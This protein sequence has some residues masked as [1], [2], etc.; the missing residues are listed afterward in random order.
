[1][2]EV[3]GHSLGEDTLE[4][5]RVVKDAIVNFGSVLNIPITHTLIMSVKNS[6]QKYQADLEAKRR[7]KE[8]TERRKRAIEKEAEQLKRKFAKDDE[9]SKID[10][11]IKSKRDG[12][13]VADETIS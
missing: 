9:V 5:L 7:L 4:A 2:L 1:M 8:E 12:I 3:D 11:D 10:E 13:A 6:Y